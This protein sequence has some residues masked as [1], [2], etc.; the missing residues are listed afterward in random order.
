MA[1]PTA[2]NG[3]IK[4]AIKI[5]RQFVKANHHLTKL[6]ADI[7]NSRPP[8]GLTPNIQAQIPE[9]DTQF[10]I[11]WEDTKLRH[12]L[13]YTQILKEYW[14]AR[15]AK[16]QQERQL[17]HT[18]IREATTQEQWTEIEKI[19]ETQADEQNREARR[20][21]PRPQRTSTPGTSRST[22][23][24]FTQGGAGGSTESNQ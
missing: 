17:L 16:I 5:E 18:T 15:K 6:T 21:R 9:K 13:E 12:A 1:I 11:T 19:L 22:N 20:R 23:V 10:V 4:A 7:E 24:T 2:Q 3:K 8:K 14:A